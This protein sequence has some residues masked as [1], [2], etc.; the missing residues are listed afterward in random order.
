MRGG[1]I[2]LRGVRGVRCQA[3]ERHHGKAFSEMDQY[4]EWALHVAPHGADDGRA[5][6][7]RVRRRL[8]RPPT[9][10]KVCPE[11]G[12]TCYAA[13]GWGSCAQLLEDDLAEFDIHPAQLRSILIHDCARSCKAAGRPELLGGGYVPGCFL[14]ALARSY[15]VVQTR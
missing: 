5:A 7:S 9:F 8:P 12:P 13:A 3:L 4:P 6:R 15:G 1:D 2:G 14:L 10:P 11:C